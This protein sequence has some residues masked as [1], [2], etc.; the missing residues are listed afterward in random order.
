MCRRE[1]DLKLG[2]DLAS[3]ILIDA[4][5]ASY[6]SGDRLFWTQLYSV[7]FTAMLIQPNDEAISTAGLIFFKVKDTV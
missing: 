3:Q 6:H 4:R 2:Q 7:P 1:F 5:I